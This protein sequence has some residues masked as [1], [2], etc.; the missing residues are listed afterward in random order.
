[1]EAHTMD[2]RKRVLDRYAG[3][4]LLGGCPVIQNVQ[5]LHLTIV[6]GDPSSSQFSSGHMPSDSS[7][8]TE[9]VR[10]ETPTK[11][12]LPSHYSRKARAALQASVRRSFRK[13][14]DT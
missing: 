10:A 3:G 12:S 2:A 4:E 1:M 7:R 5:N 9:R 8:T 14:Y 11:A 6:N 13:D